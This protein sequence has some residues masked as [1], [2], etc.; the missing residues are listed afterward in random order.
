M[1]ELLERRDDWVSRGQAA[2]E[3]SSGW[4]AALGALWFAAL[5]WALV[6]LA[7]HGAEAA[8]LRPETGKRDRERIYACRVLVHHFH[9]HKVQVWMCWCNTQLRTHERKRNPR[10]AAPLRAPALRAGDRGLLPHEV[11]ALRLPHGLHGLPHGPHGVP[12]PPARRAAYV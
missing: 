8:P 7:T 6:L 2:E 5:V 1:P 9:V 11:E 12:A 3:R 10:G 4:A